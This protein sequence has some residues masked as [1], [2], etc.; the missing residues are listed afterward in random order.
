V[1]VRYF[2]LFREQRGLSEETVATVARTV[3]DLY[4]ELATR[5]GL[6]MPLESIRCAINEEFQTFDAELSND[7]EIVF[8]PPVAG[9]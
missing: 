6:T 8:V 2:A 1:R 9:G 3:G 7:D 5:H 4:L